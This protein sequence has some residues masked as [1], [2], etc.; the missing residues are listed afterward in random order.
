MYSFYTRG[1]KDRSRV[2][3]VGRIWKGHRRDGRKRKL[4]TSP[5][6]LMLYFSET[7]I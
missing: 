7:D 1:E 4:K 2:G 3:E 6:P 5:D